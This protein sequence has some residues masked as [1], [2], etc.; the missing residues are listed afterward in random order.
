MGTDARQRFQQRQ[1]QRQKFWCE[2]CDFVTKARFA[3]TCPRCGRPMRNMGTKWRVGKRGQRE[4]WK[5]RR[6]L[7]IWRRYNPQD[8]QALLARLRG[9][10]IWDKKRGMWRARR[11]P[12]S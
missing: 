1:Q 12:E 7:S 6:D 9:E 5:P 10:V 8:G 4:N 11:A 2:P 3:A